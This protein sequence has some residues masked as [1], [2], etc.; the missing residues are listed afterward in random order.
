[1]EAA[2][3]AKLVDLQASEQDLPLN[4]WIAVVSDALAAVLP[5]GAALLKEL[6]TLRNPSPS[7]SH[8]FDGKG[9]N[10]AKTRLSLKVL[11]D[12]AQ[13][14]GDL[15]KP[16]TP[17]PTNDEIVKDISAKVM[18]EVETSTTQHLATHWVFRALYV[19]LGSLILAFLGIDFWLSKQVTAAEQTV[20]KMQDQVNGAK[21]AIFEKESDLNK[22][23]RDAESELSKSVVI[24]KDLLNGDFKKSEGEIAWVEADLTSRL[25]DDE[26]A[27]SKRIGKAGD[28]QVL[29]IRKQGAAQL[30]GIQNPYAVWLLGTSW[31]LPLAAFAFSALALAVCWRFSSTRELKRRLGITT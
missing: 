15:Y 23:L 8:G 30:A 10:D 22:A 11:L 26:R 12:K 1:M 3:R 17:M 31:V 4:L 28:D 20:T 29:A 7:P 6:E 14:I 24:S 25:K 27:R 16:P 18:R 21:A 13:V 2:T 9:D 5:P 19:I